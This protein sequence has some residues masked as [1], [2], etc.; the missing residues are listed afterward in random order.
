[1]IYNLI[2]T[3]SICRTIC[4][5]PGLSSSLH[6]E[7][8]RVPE[9]DLLHVVGLQQ[10]HP[11]HHRSTELSLRRWQACPPSAPCPCSRN[12]RDPDKPTTFADASSGSE[13][14]IASSEYRFLFCRTEKT[15]LMCVHF[16]RFHF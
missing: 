9:A 6:V 8:Q 2:S 11:D 15:F 7:R 3:D 12:Y 16:R 10:R 14:V 13:L 1:M 5:P 4:L